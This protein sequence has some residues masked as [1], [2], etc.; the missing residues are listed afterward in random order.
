LDIRNNHLEYAITW[1][2]LAMTLA[3]VY[4]AF[5]VKSGKKT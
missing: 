4:V 3:I 5:T 1:F 2:L